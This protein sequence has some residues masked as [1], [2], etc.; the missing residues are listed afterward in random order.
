MVTRKALQNTSFLPT[1]CRRMPR[2]ASPATFLVFKR[3]KTKGASNHKP[4]CM[5][6]ASPKR[7]MGGGGPKWKTDYKICPRKM[8]DPHKTNISPDILLSRVLKAHEK[9]K[10]VLQFSLECWTWFRMILL[11]AP[12]GESFH[13]SRGR[14]SGVRSRPSLSVGTPTLTCG[15]EN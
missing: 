2:Q 4:I 12:R 1:R 6:P 9:T 10:W 3:L 5:H 14:E 7:G 8:Q 11:A 15:W 13:S